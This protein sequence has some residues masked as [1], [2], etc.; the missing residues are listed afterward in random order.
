MAPWP[1]GVQGRPAG[2]ALGQV[3]DTS[4]EEV[5][6]A[7]FLLDRTGTLSFAMWR[8]KGE[9]KDRTSLLPSGMKMVGNGR[10]NP[11]TVIVL[12]FFLAGNRSGNGKD[13][14]ENEFDITGYRK[15]KL[16]IGNISITMG[17]YQ[18]RS[19]TRHM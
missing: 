16:R 17:K 1:T 19:G 6:L 10:E 8:Q 15:W 11:Q 9:R 4:Y 5:E 7:L 2:D 12:V 14:R 13:G 3:R 18:L